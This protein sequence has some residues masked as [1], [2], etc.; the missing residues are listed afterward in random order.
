MHDYEP[1]VRGKQ[2]T[3]E[4]VL[5][6]IIYYKGESLYFCLFLSHAKTNPISIIFVEQKHYNLDKDRLLF[7]SV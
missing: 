6:T 1:V 3:Y 4:L 7:I 2:T 5:T